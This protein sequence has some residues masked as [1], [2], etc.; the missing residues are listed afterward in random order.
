MAQ[1][2]IFFFR[3]SFVT[4]CSKAIALSRHLP[5]NLSSVPSVSFAKQTKSPFAAHNPHTNIAEALTTHLRLKIP[6]KS[7]VYENIYVA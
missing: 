7:R 3:R 5:C 1:Q 4:T 2:H 6:A